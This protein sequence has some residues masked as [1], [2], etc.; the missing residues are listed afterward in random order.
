MNTLIDRL[1]NLQAHAIYR[2]YTCAMARPADAPL[3]T[4]RP[5]DPTTKY[6]Y[7]LGAFTKPVFAISAEHGYGPYI[8]DGLSIWGSAQVGTV[9]HFMRAG[10]SHIDLLTARDQDT[11]I[12]TD[13]LRWLDE[14]GF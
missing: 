13:L 2:D 12:N 3:A 8:A 11:M 9:T 4:D 10:V 5:N 6:I 1:N 14:N 7:N